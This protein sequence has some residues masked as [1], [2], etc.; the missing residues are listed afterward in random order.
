MSEVKEL[1]LFFYEEAKDMGMSD[2][3][4]KAWAYDKMDYQVETLEKIY[5]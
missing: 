2:E 3:D 4:A 1:L 5:E